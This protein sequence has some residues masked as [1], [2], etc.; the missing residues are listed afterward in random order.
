M[1]SIFNGINKSTFITEKA[2][3]ATLHNERDSPANHQTYIFP[4]E[5]FSSSRYFYYRP[6]S[7]P[8]QLNQCGSKCYD[9][10]Y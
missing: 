1:K 5:P 3:D 9:R 8:K 4:K 10:K 7:F 6:G 2:I